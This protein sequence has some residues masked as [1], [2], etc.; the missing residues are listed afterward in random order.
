MKDFYR[1]L[2]SAVAVIGIFFIADYSFGIILDKTAVFVD[3]PKY[4]RI[5]KGKEE[6]V[7]LGASRACN[8]YVTRILEDSLGVS[9]YNYG[10]GAQNV[11]T[12]YAVLSLLIEK[13]AKKP[14][15]V[16][17]DIYYTDILNTPGWNTEKTGILFSAYNYDEAVREIVDLQEG[18]KSKLIRYV[19]LYKFNSK[20][21]YFIIDYKSKKNEDISGG[22]SPLYFEHNKP[23]EIRNTGRSKYD[24]QKLSYIDKFIHLCKEND[25][26]LYVFISPAFYK[27]ENGEAPEDWA[28]VIEKKCLDNAIPVYNHEQDSL[29]LIH[30]EWFYNSEHLNDTGA[31]IYTTIV[32]KK[33]MKM[34]ESE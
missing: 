2:L 18:I 24:M 34:V 26:L 22:Y 12:N 10:V 31:K 1:F 16:I 15:Y 21:P 7:V 8:Q 23:I 11:Y 13:G 9:A 28:K 20:I 4:K 25:I 33:L 32:A 3:A 19:N 14:K 30:P 6:L 17:W 27:L 5:E 29:F